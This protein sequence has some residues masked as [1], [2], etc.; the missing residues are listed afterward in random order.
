MIG[1]IELNFHYNIRYTLLQGKSVVRKYFV[2]HL[3]TEVGGVGSW[4]LGEGPEGRA[5]EMGP[6]SWAKG[7]K[8]LPTGR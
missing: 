1:N 2:L 4:A 6:G 8:K 7:L 5:Q 3:H